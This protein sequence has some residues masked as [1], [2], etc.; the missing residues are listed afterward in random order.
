MNRRTFIKTTSLAGVAVTATNAAHLTSHIAHRELQL[1]PATGGQAT[2]KSPLVINTWDY[3]QIVTETAYQTMSNGGSVLDAVEKAVMIPEADP[4]IT[5]VGRG[6]FPDKDGKVTLDAS[7]MDGNGNCGSVVFLEH[8]L[9]P[10]SVARLVMEKTQHVYL[11]GEGALQFALQNGFAKEN[12]L[13]EKAKKEY[14]KWLLESNDE[15][16]KKRKENHDTIGL[17]AMDANGNMAGACSSSGMAWKIRGR[18]G[19]SPIIGAG[20]YVDNEVGAAT[21]T[22]IGE[23]VIKVCGSF[24]IV[25]L[26]RQGKSPQDACQLALERILHKQPKYKVENNFLVGFCAF[27]KDG[28]HGGFCYKKGFEYSVYKEGKFEVVKSKYLK[29]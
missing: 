18:V 21:A 2:N 5:S 23:A 29:D 22:G 24:L 17:I 28:E 19:D 14:E 3:K 25:E 1:S 13:T 6:G 12:L 8:I 10:V 9:Y 20:L 4:E 26:M 15:S 7:I 16:I 27:N 11:A